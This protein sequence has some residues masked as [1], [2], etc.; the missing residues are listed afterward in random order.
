MRPTLAELFTKGALV[1]GAALLVGLAA[2]V[3]EVDRSVVLEALRQAARGRS[4]SRS[5]PPVVF[6][7]RVPTGGARS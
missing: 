1:F 4:K 2:S 3:L 7:Q 5:G 6:L